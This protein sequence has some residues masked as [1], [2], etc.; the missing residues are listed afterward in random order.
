MN[1]TKKFREKRWKNIMKRIICFN[2][3][4]QNES[5]PLQL[6]ILKEFSFEYLVEITEKIEDVMK[7][8]KIERKSGK[9][10]RKHQL[11]R[12][13]EGFEE[14]AQKILKYAIYYKIADG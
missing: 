2:K 6:S 13:V 10:Q 4:C 14:D 11:Q 7:Q 12:F 1:A 9:G 5:I 8:K 3:Y